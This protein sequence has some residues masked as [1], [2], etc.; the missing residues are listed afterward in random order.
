MENAGQ[1]G[2]YDDS[3]LDPG[4]TLLGLDRDQNDGLTDGVM[5]GYEPV[6]FTPISFGEIR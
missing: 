6:K 4:R 2:Q 1:D 5:K 3:E